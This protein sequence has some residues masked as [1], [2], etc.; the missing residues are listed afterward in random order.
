MTKPTMQKTPRVWKRPKT[1]TELWNELYA[2][3][4]ADGLVLQRAL[5]PNAEVRRG[6]Y[7]LR[8]YFSGGIVH[9]TADLR[10]MRTWLMATPEQRRRTE[11]EKKNPQVFQ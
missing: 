8:D 9:G 7:F 4:R 1:G 10:A 2:L 3:A 5:R 6:R 11:E